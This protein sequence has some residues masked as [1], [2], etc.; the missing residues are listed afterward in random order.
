[1][2][3]EL[4]PALTRKLIPAEA[5]AQVPGYTPAAHIAALAGGAVNRT[6]RVNTPDGCFVLRLHS[7]TGATLGA[8][9]F[10]EAQLQNAAA[11]AGVAPKVIHIDPRQRFMV[12]EFIAGRVWTE[13]DF[14]DA[15]QIKRLGA[16]LRILH[17]VQALI[18]APFDLA[19]LLRGFS[20]G[21]ARAAPAER[22]LLE[23]LMARADL[24]LRGSGS[25]MRPPTLFH[26]DLKHSNI[27]DRGDTLVLIDWEYAAVGDP[28]YDPACVLAYYPQVKPHA[29]E[30]LE[31]SG[32]AAAASLAML[33]HASW[34]YVLLSFFWERARQL[35]TSPG[36]GVRLATPAD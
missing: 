9:H 26:S 12:S 8:D 4:S 1:M 15:A 14:S 17:E 28:L 36:A 21:I 30:L 11:A 34:L 29:R 24:S 18:S 20:D 7:P 13:S 10:R 5:L 22:P 33:E 3:S 32:L 27:I 2:V 31:S 19:A 23:Q 6:F 16:T 25:A 35:A